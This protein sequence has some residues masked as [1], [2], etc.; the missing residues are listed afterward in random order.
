MYYKKSISNKVFDG[1]LYFFM[2]LL[3][4]IMVY[5]LAHVL[6]LSLSS[7]SAVADNKV[8]FYPINMHLRGYVNVFF[9]PYFWRSY[10][11][12]IIYAAVGAVLCLTLTSLIAY[13]LSLKEFVFRRSLTVFVLI[14]IFFSGGLIPSY[15]IMRSIGLYNNYLVMVLPTALLGYNI[16][17][18]RTFFAQMPSELRESAKIDGAN[19]FI[20]LFKIIMPLSK[21]LLATFALFSIVAFWNDWFAANLYLLD[22]YKMPLQFILRRLVV[23]AQFNPSNG[24]INEY[25]QLMQNGLM[26]QKNMQMAAVV[27]SIIPIM[28]IYPA[29]MKYFEKGMMI[30]SVKG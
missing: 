25:Q 5:P 20:I 24:V 21:P 10:L 30:G 9:Y 22:M 1:F 29:I 15:L 18:F 17:I 7:F 12:S 16:I 23:Q 14:T 4:I 11:N 2:S 6:S 19:D 27:I 13:P 8:T 28:C 3:A 26:H